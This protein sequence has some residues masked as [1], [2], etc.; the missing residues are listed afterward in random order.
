MTVELVACPWHQLHF[1]TQGFNLNAAGWNL[2]NPAA[3][4][5]QPRATI[6]LVISGDCGTIGIMVSTAIP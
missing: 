5:P 3:G 6:L 1:L 2:K 4:Q